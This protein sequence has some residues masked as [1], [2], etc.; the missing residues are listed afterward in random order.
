MHAL[1]LSSFEKQAD[2]P[3]EKILTG[4]I[5]FE[6]ATAQFYF[7]KHSVL[8]HIMHAFL[9]IKATKTWGIS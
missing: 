1:P 5:E 9:N 7:T 8:Q 2:N 4:R 3:V 6:K